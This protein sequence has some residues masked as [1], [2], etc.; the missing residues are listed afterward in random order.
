MLGCRACHLVDGKG[1]QIGPNLSGIGQRM[2]RQELQ[3]ILLF[4]NDTNP[5]H[6]MPRYDYLFESERQQLLN[7]LEQQ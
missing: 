2:T 7:I 4:H 1:G 5:E 3:R 6:P